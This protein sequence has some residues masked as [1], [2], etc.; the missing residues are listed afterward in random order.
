[1]PPR[2]RKFLTAVLA[3]GA[4]GLIHH[5]I[6]GDGI[7]G[8]QLLSFYLGLF[9]LAVLSLSRPLETY[10]LSIAISV[11][12]I[13][14]WIAVKFVI[15]AITTN[16]AATARAMWLFWGFYG[17][18]GLVANALMVTVAVWIRRRFYPIYGIGLCQNCGYDLTGNVSGRCPECGTA[19]ER[20]DQAT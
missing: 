15:A 8:L 7:A 14:G 19:V 4:L 5:A 11:I 16:Y 18:L 9:P 20:E 10:R 13:L 17:F 12:A 2:D 3:G 6:P 1:M